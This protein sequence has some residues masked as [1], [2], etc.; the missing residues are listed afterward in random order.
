MNSLRALC[1]LIERNALR[2][3]I[4]FTICLL[5]PPTCSVPLQQDNYELKVNK[6]TK[7]AMHQYLKDRQ[8]CTVVILHARV[9]QKSYGNEKRWMNNALCESIMLCCIAP[10]TS[11]CLAL[12]YVQ[13]TAIW[14]D[15]NFTQSVAVKFS[16]IQ[17]SCVM[18]S[19][20]LNLVVTRNL[21]IHV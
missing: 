21:M 20:T 18:V 5:M 13:T 2:D 7:E 9:A 8:D 19:A 17:A 12:N 10:S 15:F 3:Q 14:T 6:L 4:I 1:S 16:N 11:S